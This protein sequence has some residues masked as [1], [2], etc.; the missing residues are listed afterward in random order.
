MATSTFNGSIPVWSEAVRLA[1]LQDLEVLDTPPET[2]FDDAVEI[3]VQ[4]C[5]TSSASIGFVTGNRHWFKAKVG[6]EEDEIPS[7]IS[8]G[9]YAMRQDGLVVIGDLREHPSSAPTHS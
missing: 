6:F 2:A 3:A 5:Q 4:V 7:D 1:A 9:S 8:I